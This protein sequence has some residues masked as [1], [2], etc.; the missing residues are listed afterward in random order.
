MIYSVDPVM[1]RRCPLP[2]KRR[3]IYGSTRG[4]LRDIYRTYGSPIGMLAGFYTTISPMGI[5]LGP[6]SLPSS[7]H[8][9][10]RQGAVESRAEAISSRN[11]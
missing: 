8:C 5:G 9:E 11:L 10:A 7:R 3:D 2:Y 4:Q 1:S 6:S